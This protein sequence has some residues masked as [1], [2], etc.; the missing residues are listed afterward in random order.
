MDSKLTKPALNPEEPIPGQHVRGGA[1]REGDR[2]PVCPCPAYLSLHTSELTFR[3][4]GQFRPRRQGRGREGD[5]T[6]AMSVQYKLP[7]CWC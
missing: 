5:V 2:A 7:V 1:E 6:V 4:V 3:P